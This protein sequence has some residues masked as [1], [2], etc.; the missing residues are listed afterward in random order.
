MDKQTIQALKG[1]LLAVKALKDSMEK[2]LA[3]TSNDNIWKY[4]SFKMYMSTYQNI[5]NQV[6]GLINITAPIGIWGK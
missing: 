4:A 3:S 2:S 5:V 1:H 6:S